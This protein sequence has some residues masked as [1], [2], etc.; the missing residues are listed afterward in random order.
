MH[1]LMAQHGLKPITE[2]SIAH[3]KYFFRSVDYLIKE[4]G[5]G[6]LVKTLK[7]LIKLFYPLITALNKGD[8]LFL[9]YE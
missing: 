4:T 1:S 7:P 3:K 5:R 8:K 9:I 6:T 2:K